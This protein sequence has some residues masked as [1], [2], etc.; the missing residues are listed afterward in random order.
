MPD[1]ARLRDST[2][3]VLPCEALDGVREQLE[4][5]FT[6]TVHSRDGDNCQ[7]IASPVEITEVAKF[8]TRHGIPV[9]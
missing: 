2:Q 4:T 9:E 1:P 8:L 5:E 7:I 6:V 3:I